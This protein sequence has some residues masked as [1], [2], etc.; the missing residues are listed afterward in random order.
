[1]MVSKSNIIENT[2]KEF[3]DRVKAQVLSTS[4][5]GSVTVTVQNYVSSFPDQLID[6]K[7]EYPII[8][9]ETPN[10]SGEVFTIGKDKLAGTIKIEIYATQA[11]AADKLFSQVI[12]S[13][14]TYKRELREAGLTMV[15]LDDTD[16]DHISRDKI[17]I[18]TRMAQFKFS[19]QYVK[20]GAY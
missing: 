9:V 12:D 13:I 15:K 11:E 2:W 10:F 7:S 18:H 14:E 5:T 6:S 20:T 16:S 1:M 4:I 3:Y 17:N 19:F 8:V